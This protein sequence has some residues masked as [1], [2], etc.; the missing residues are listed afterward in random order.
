MEDFDYIEVGSIT[1]FFGLK[2]GVKLFSLTRPR[3]NIQ[4]YKYFFY[5]DTKEKTKKKVVLFE[6]KES[7][8]NI[9]A[10]IRGTNSREEAQV[11]LGKKLYIKPDQLEKLENEYYWYDLI[12]L[13]VFSLKNEYLGKVNSLIETG[14]N[15]VLVIKSDEKETLIPFII[16]K[17]VISVDLEL[18]KIIVD[19]N[20]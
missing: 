10:K 9:V 19:W 14:A 5:S 6:I 11:F 17:Y 18:K 7:G 3:G 8:K 12:G 2:G 16:N 15:D 1:G 20:D 13:S 4:K